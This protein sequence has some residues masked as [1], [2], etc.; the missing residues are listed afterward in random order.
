MVQ[1]IGMGYVAWK[2]SEPPGYGVVGVL[3]MVE[4]IKRIENDTGEH[5]S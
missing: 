1:I 2:D 4:S 5:E 3:G